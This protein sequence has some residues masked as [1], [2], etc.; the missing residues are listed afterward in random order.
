MLCERLKS[1]QLPLL[2]SIGIVD[3]RARGS[4]PREKQGI[5]GKASF[6]LFSSD[7]FFLRICQMPI[8]RVTI[9][10][11]RRSA[12]LGGGRHREELAAG[13]FSY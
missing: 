12:I 5:G 4:K 2:S 1:G 7:G 3:L 10:L 8:W 6:S 11:S 9:R 13:H